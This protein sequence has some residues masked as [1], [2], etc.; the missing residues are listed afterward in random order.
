MKKLMGI[1]AAAAYLAVAALNIQAQ[2][3]ADGPRFNGTML[4]RPTDYR[5]WPF[6]GSALGLTYDNGGNAN[7]NPTFTNVFVNPSSF[8]RFM[9]T[10]TWPNATIF[11]LEFRRSETG[12]EPNKGGRYQGQLVGLE[13]EVKD[14][15]FADNWG[16]FQFGRADAM[17]AEVAPLTG[18]AVAACVECHTKN[19]AVERTFAQFYP[20]ILEVARQKGTVR[21]GF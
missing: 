11:V 14:S 2:A 8:Q 1:A 17:P 19:T 3:P 5:A 10:G 6:L 21:P 18:D 12:A 9:Q 16:F 13:A 4:V 7:P 15:R 20:T